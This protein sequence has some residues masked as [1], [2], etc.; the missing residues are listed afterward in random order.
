MAKQKNVTA[1]ARI[2]INTSA[3]IAAYLDD[4]VSIGIQGKTRAEVAERLVSAGV[5]Q[6]IK[7]DLLKLHKMNS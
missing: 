5:Q 4:L 3:E 2:T 1:T 7:D 6:L